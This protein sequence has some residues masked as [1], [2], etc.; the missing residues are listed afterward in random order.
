[1]RVGSCAESRA[2]W[3]GLSIGNACQFDRSL[4]GTQATRQERAVF[5]PFTEREP[6]RYA[7]VASAGQFGSKL[8]VGCRGVCVQGFL[9]FL[10]GEFA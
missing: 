1:M 4:F 6:A 10:T 5:T 3:A 2:S 8:H 9:G 7:V